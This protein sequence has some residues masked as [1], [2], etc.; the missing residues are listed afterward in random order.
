MSSDPY[1]NPDSK[2]KYSAKTNIPAFPRSRKPY[3]SFGGPHSRIQIR[4]R[5]MQLPSTATNPVL[6]KRRAKTAA[7]LEALAKKGTRFT[8][9][10]R[11]AIR[12]IAARPRYIAKGG[13]IVKGPNS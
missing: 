4:K 1:K 10:E 9:G 13:F 6:G 5:M 2:R 8:P 11:A 12:G 3:V 7:Q